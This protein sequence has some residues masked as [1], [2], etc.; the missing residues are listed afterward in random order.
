MPYN[1]LFIFDFSEYFR[2]T[3]KTN[4]SKYCPVY[5]GRP[6]LT[7]FALDVPEPLIIIFL[8]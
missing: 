1:Y 8:S 2:T 7:K 4:L 6:P 3:A 5:S